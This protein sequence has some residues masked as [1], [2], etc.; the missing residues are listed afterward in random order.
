M[1]QPVP[2]IN[3]DLFDGT[4]SISLPSSFQNI[5]DKSYVPDNQEVFTDIDGDGHLVIEITEPPQI[6]DTEAAKYYFD[7]L[8]ECNESQENTI[9][10][11]TFTPPDQMPSL[12]YFF[13]A[14]KAYK[15]H[16]L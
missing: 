14:I 4:F 3:Q 7:D 8:A 6:P 13:S 5:R 16:Q 1:A 10:L 2:Y 15:V 12:E 11:S 9:N